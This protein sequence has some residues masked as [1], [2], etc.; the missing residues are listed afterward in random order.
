MANI[1]VQFVN[2]N[3]AAYNFR[4]DVSEGDSK[5]SHRVELVKEHYLNLTDGKVAP[6]ELIQC[7]FEFLLEREPKESILSSFNVS[8]ISRY[9][10]EYERE[11]IN[12]F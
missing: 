11:I 12:Y 4:V 9:F 1:V 3:D 7:S 5:T 6:E 8:V 10:P 2:E